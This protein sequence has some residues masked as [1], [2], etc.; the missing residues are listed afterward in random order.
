MKSQDIVNILK[1]LP[2]VRLRLLEL[3]QL[4]VDDEGEP[5]MNKIAFYAKEMVEATSEA[6]AYSSETRKAVAWLRRLVRS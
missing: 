3:A 1:Q 5:D 4:V 6:E 2:P